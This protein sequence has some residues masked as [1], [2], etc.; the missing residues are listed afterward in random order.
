MGQRYVEL[1]NTYSSS[2]DN[3]A[4]F[5]HVSQ[6]PP[7]P[8]IIAPGPALFFVVVNSIPSIGVQVTI[9]SGELGTQ[10][11]LPVD[12]LPASSLSDPKQNENATSRGG[13][14]GKVNGG[15]RSL[16]GPPADTWMIVFVS[17]LVGSL[18]LTYFGL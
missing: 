13:G 7:N 10:K 3:S 18:G 2:D 11:I 1:E 12:P 15:S 4:G 5:L 17:V 16:R 8:S 14:E 9:G 6:V